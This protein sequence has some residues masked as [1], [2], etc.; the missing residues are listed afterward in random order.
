MPLAGGLLTRKM[1]SVEGSRTSEVE[2]EY[3]ITLGETNQQMAAFSNLCQEI[4]EQ[5]HVVAIAW[6]LSHP[7]VAAPI[8]GIRTL[9]QLD[10]LDRAA[11]LELDAEVLDTLDEI[12]N[13]NLGRP[14][15]IGQ[16]PEAYAW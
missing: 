4:G 12:F 7:A 16:A 9:E 10:G 3:G 6:T 1:K 2:R 13:P 15:R 11:E 5:E 14:L 8:V